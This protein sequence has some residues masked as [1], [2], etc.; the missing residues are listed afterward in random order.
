MT[1]FIHPKR[2]IGDI[3][4]EFNQVYPFLKVE[5]FRVPHGNQQGSPLQN[6]LPRHLTLQAIAPAIPTGEIALA[7][8]M[9][10]VQLEGIF[11]QQFG[12]HVQVFRKSG[13]LWLET[14]MTDSWTL[15]QQNDHGQEMSREF[16][17]GS[18]ES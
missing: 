17:V 15:K 12:L 10:V 5:L 14:T 8:A 11:Q 7:D 1:I 16:G 18:Q 4:Q 2:L 13:N 6:R 9:S 3:Q